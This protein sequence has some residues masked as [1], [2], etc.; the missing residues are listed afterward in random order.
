MFRPRFVGCVHLAVSVVSS[1]CCARRPQFATPNC[2]HLGAR[3]AG[4]VAVPL[5]SA[6]VVTGGS[7]GGGGCGLRGGGG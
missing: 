1:P 6:L 2:R 5:E 4:L 3:E 7:E